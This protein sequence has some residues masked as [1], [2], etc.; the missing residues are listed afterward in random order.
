MQKEAAAKAAEVVEEPEDVTS[1]RAI[2]LRPCLYSFHRSSLVEEYRCGAGGCLHV[3]REHIR[4]QSVYEHKVL[5]SMLYY[6]TLD[7][8][9][10]IAEEAVATLTDLTALS[11]YYLLLP[12]LA[13]QIT[14]AFIA[15]PNF[16]QLVSR[17]PEM[18]LALGT[19]LHSY[20]IFA[21]ALRHVVGRSTLP[22][23][24]RS[25]FYQGRPTEEVEGL[26][27][28][29]ADDLRRRTDALT[30]QLREIGLS[31]CQAHPEA[32]T[33]RKRGPL[34]RTTWLASGTGKKDLDDK[35]RWIAASVYREKLDQLIYGEPHWSHVEYIRNGRKDGDVE[36][37]SL[38][39]A[40]R[41]LFAAH[42][43]PENLTLF[44]HNAAAKFAG[45]FNLHAQRTRDLNPAA[46]IATHLR[47]LVRAAVHAIQYWV[48]LAG[49][50]PNEYAGTEPAKYG[51]QGVEY[52]TAISV[53]QWECP[54]E[55]QEEVIDEEGEVLEGTMWGQFE[56]GVEGVVASEEWVEVVGS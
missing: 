30:R 48:P 23:Y 22:H 35:C 50:P 42:R 21:D 26:A 3:F 43:N 16:W 17:Y 28:N 4:V 37:G 40:C 34:V 54:W 53:G 29:K 33:K 32:E 44:G 11:E 47:R 14:A 49:A 41:A 39:I 36:A 18:Y 45:I 46:R 13:H 9:L 19:K 1:L 24:H 25:L 10:G 8:D 6:G 12:S 20:E 55:W 52:F 27:K 56:G 2:M 5:F 38:F 15:I 51:G 7:I 31:F